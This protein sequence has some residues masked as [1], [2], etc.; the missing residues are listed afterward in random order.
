[1]TDQTDTDAL[2]ERVKVALVEAAGYPAHYARH[3]Q[4]YDQYP[5]LII[6]KAF[7]AMPEATTQ[8]AQIAALTERVRVLEGALEP[9]TRG[10]DGTSLA[11][12]Y[13]HLNRQHYHT[14][15]TALASKEPTND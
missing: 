15:R 14:A 4:D 2:V 3:C 13:A 11:K 1:M 10:P 6:V 5:V 9:F 8:A 7:A 12:L